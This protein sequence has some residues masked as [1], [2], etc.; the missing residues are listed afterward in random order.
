[1]AAGCL[2]RMQLKAN[3]VR[4]H[5]PKVA[6]YTSISPNII[7]ARLSL[8][9]KMHYGQIGARVTIVKKT[10]TLTFNFMDGLEKK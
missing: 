3:L 5:S 6:A 8:D 2:K 4:S 9:V 10:E 1:M 7:P